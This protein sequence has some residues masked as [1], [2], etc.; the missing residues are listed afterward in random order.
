MVI[1]YKSLPG[2]GDG[3][4]KQKHS[5]WLFILV[6]SM[7]GAEGLGEGHGEER[8]LPLDYVLYIAFLQFYVICLYHLFKSI[9]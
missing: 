3:L 4:R 5:K 2:Y 1:Y 9:N 6:P 8:E 7:A